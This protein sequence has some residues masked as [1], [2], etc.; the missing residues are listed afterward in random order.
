MSEVVVKGQS[1]PIDSRIQEV[2]NKSFNPDNVEETETPVEETKQET[3]AET[4]EEVK[5][6][7]TIDVNNIDEVDVEEEATE[8]P[9]RAEKRIRELNDKKN[10]AE[11][12]VHTLELQVAEMKPYLEMLKAQ[13]TEKV[14]EDTPILPQD[15][16]TQEEFA[17]AILAKAEENVMAK[18]EDRLAPLQHTQANNQYLSN[19]NDYFTNNPEAQEVKGAMDKLSEKFNDKTRAFYT[20]QILEGDTSVLD[21][22]YLKSKPVKVD[23][24]GLINTA[25]KEDQT[26]AAIGTAKKATKSSKVVNSGNSYDKAMKTGDVTDY[27]KEWFMAMEKNLK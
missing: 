9:S 2:L 25:I 7:P 10:L 5:E 1:E 16:D 3:P 26:K 17:K 23:N 18:L 8:K 27:A 24:S 12:K 15:Y 19:I 14:V 22:L 13:T 4:V 6:D 20:E 11:E 21:Y